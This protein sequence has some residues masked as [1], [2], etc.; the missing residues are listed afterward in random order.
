MVE[1]TLAGVAK[2][3]GI[4]EDVETLDPSFI[5]VRRNRLIFWL[6][7][8]AGSCPGCYT[9]QILSQVLAVLVL[10]SHFNLTLLC[11]LIFI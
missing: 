3:N 11:T 4:D 8:G 5:T 1:S 7:M 10:N 6:R 9:S 2:N